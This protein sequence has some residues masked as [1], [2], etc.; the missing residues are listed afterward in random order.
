MSLFPEHACILAGPSVFQTEEVDSVDISGLVTGQ[1][2]K[3]FGRGMPVSGGWGAE[4][5]APEVRRK[6]TLPRRPA[7]RSR[8]AVPALDPL[9]VLPPQPA[10]GL[11][12]SLQI[13]FLS[14]QIPFLHISVSLDWRRISTHL[15]RESS[16]APLGATL[17]GR[18]ESRA[19]V[20]LTA[21]L[22]GAHAQRATLVPGSKANYI[23]NE[24]F[25]IRAGIS[26]L[27]AG[28]HDRAEK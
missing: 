21:A 2:G 1:W 17:L 27:P 16:R 9:A 26:D 5:K 6:E 28:S 14:P 25:E 19:H 13:P 8:E 20:L 15:T 4:N 18:R 11:F 7:S 3:Y 12:R 22:W 23:T 24:H 10:H